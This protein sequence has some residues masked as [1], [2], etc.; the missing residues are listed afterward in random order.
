M[1]D[2]DDTP[3]I[4]FHDTSCFQICKKSDASAMLFILVI[5]QDVLGHLST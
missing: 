5:S 1:S 3:A 4:P 2:N